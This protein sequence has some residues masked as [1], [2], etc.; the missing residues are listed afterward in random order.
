MS[1][2]LILFVSLFVWAAFSH[3][4]ALGGMS[5][6]VRGLHLLLML[7]MGA[8]LYPMAMG[9]ERKVEV[10]IGEHQLGVVLWD[11]SSSMTKDTQLR[12]RW[13]KEIRSGS[14]GQV[15]WMEYSEELLPPWGEG[16]GEQGTSLQKALSQLE[17]SL[18]KLAPDWVWVLSDMGASPP[19]VVGKNWEGIDLYLTP[20]QPPLSSEGDI[21]IEGVIRDPVWYSRTPSPVRVRL[22]RDQDSE[23]EEVDLL[24]H[25]NGDLVT[26]TKCFFEKGKKV[27][28]AVVDLQAREVGP[29]LMEV[30][31]AEGQGGIRPENDQW[32]D[33][34]ESL[35]DRIRILRVVGRPTWSSKY[36][37]DALVKREDVDL[38]DFH[39]LR[40]MNDMVMAVPDDLALIPFPV[41]ELFV[42]NIDSFDLVLW[43]NFNQDQYPFFRPGYLK[44]ILREVRSGTGLLLWSGTLPWRW[45]RGALREMAPLVTEGRDHKEVSGTLY[46]TSG[47]LGWPDSLGK[48]LENLPERKYRIFE[49]E[50]QKG[51]RVAL[52]LNDQPLITLKELGKGRVAQVLSDQLWAWSFSEEGSS[53]GIYEEVLGRLLLW[54]QKHPDV[55]R[56]EIEAP[57]VARGG[58]RIQVQ[59]GEPMG[60]NSKPV[61]TSKD[62][63]R[64]LGEESFMKGEKAVSLKVPNVPGYHRLSFDGVEG[65]AQIGIRGLQGEFWEPERREATTKTMLQHGW[66][67]L[68]EGERPLG[69]DGREIGTHERD[70]GWPSYRNPLYASAWLIL[71]I[72]H[73]LI[74]NRI[75]LGKEKSG[76][77][78]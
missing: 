49:G 66:K 38:V 48:S 20:L 33:E 32:I 71:L 55:E 64:S 62:G 9:W 4:R 50:L 12:E 75:L 60:V 24:F 29:I 46:A 28:E 35:R 3:Q 25:L 69:K 53:M 15:E 27:A 65:E 57:R 18:P 59:L 41:E 68:K 47:E 17:E 45:D 26:T 73:W 43:Q 52:S 13:S 31:I 44:N 19:S 37:R 42:E 72:L 2:V 22:T 11:A 74:T 54:L 61:W 56:K 51:A 58:Q 23:T 70:S 8:L 76:T 30:S 40:S 34:V 67:L 36:L 39:I 77:L 16:S 78:G 10:P 21:G 14:F 6:K 5:L 63:E 1:W 7:F